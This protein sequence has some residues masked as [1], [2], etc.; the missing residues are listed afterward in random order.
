[1]VDGRNKYQSQENREIVRQVLMDEWDPIG[2]KDIPEA[3][4]EY[5]TYVGRI[6]V[7]L[8]DEK[9]SK[10]SM[11]TYLYNVATNHMGISPSPLL[12]ERSIQAADIISEL[13]PN[14]ETH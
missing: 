2:V 11:A 6:Y 10:Q 4:D 1:M 3:L 13:R 7:M 5:D 9:A 14:F 8:M 12:M